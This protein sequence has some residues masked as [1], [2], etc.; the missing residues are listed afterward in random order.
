MGDFVG[1]I[2]ELIKIIGLQIQT[3]LNYHRKF[4]KYVDDLNKVQADLQARKADI[5]KQL[6]DEHHFGKKPKQKVENWLK[7]VEDKITCAQGVEDKVSNGKYLFR[8]CLG[9]L[10]D[11]VTQEIK[12][13][14]ADGDFSGSLV[15]NDP[16][17]TKLT[18][19][20]EELVGTAKVE[21][22]YEYLMGD[23]V[24]KIGVWGMGGIGK[25]TIMKHVHNMLLEETKFKKLI[26]TTISQ[27]FDV[28]RLQQQ[29]ASQLKE[30]LSDHEDTTVRAAKLSAMLGKQGRYLLIL[31]DVW[32]SF[33]LKD[34]GI[35]EP[36]ANN[37]CKLVLTTRLREVV[38]SM[39][40]KEVQVPCLSLDQAWQLYLSKVGQDMLPNPSTQSTMELVVKECD[41]LPLAIVTVASCMRGKYD[42]PA[43]ENALNELRGYI[44]NI[45]D[46]E[47][48]VYGCLKFSYDRLKQ[49]DRDCF[50]YCAL[51]PEDYEIEKEEMIEFW[52]EEGL[53]DEMGTRQAM[54]DSGHSI[55]HKLQENCLL[56]RAEKGTHI[57]MHDVVRDMALHITKRSPQFFVKAGM[58]LTELLD[59]QWTE[60]LEKVS[61]MRNSITKISPIMQPFKCQKLTTLLLSD[62]RLKEI[63]ESFFVQMPNLKILD[64]SRNYS[65]VGLPDSLSNL[66]NLTALLLSS[67]EGLKNVPSL[68]KLKAL[69]KVDLKRT[70]ISKIPQGLELLVN[71]RYLNLGSTEDLE[72]IPNGVLSKLCRLQYLAIHPASTRAD[73]MKELNKLEVFEGCFSKI[74]DFNMF[75]C[76]RNKLHEYLIL[77][78]HQQMDACKDYYSYRSIFDHKDIYHSKTVAFIDIHINFG[79]GI[80]VPYD[81]QQLTISNCKGMRTL[82]DIGGLKDSADLKECDIWYVDELESV[83]SSKCRQL[84]TLESLQLYC[85]KNLKAIA[86]EPLVGALSSLK[87]I[88]L[89]NCGKIKNLLS[90]NWVLHNLE[91][92]TVKECEEMEDIIES[93]GE[94]MGTNNN[95][96]VYILSKLRTLKLEKL[97][98]LKRICSKNGVMVCDSLQHIIVVNCPQLK[99]I[100]LYLPLVDHD[101]GK[102]SPPPSL[103]EICVH[104]KEWWESME[105]DHPHAKNVLIPYLRFWN[106]RTYQWRQSV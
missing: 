38:R 85:W 18:L 67:C 95:T 100:P 46:M 75:A 25:T 30:T 10:V 82:N 81:I 24:R 102:P 7:K 22:I 21:E 52:M 78:C 89:D 90:A 92:I 41:G 16:S 99:R 101:N 35:L 77:V 72:E 31:D 55:L 69:K 28:R 12:E 106:N 20:T 45:Q 13:V 17:T 56:E 57:K 97:P 43:W 48:K 49:I 37:S 88:L 60:D 76:Q 8:S 53:I 80:I 40:F 105:L 27:D 61:L 1:P 64:L 94:E 65:I 19:P 96:I 91:E 2:L 98:K 86:G 103:E 58:Q 83:F 4:D 3:C 59:E 26:W 70:R 14:H 11:E 62:N 63:A 15:V 50:L 47:E 104:P 87:K 93:E 9:K 29:I 44:R 42:S 66:E 74:G 34:V 51:Y 32:S 5:E 36:T 39:G 23:E 84:D 71:L 33:S 6:Q 73:E 54:H 68:L 79:D